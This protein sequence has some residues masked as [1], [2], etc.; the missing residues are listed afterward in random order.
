[1]TRL[2]PF[3]PI[4]KR[5]MKHDTITEPI[6]I[7]NPWGKMIITCRQL[8]IY[9]ET[10]LLSLLVLLNEQDSNTFQ[11]TPYELCKLMGVKPARDTY[12]AIMK[13][14]DRMSE[15]HITMKIKKSNHTHGDMDGHII[16]SITKNKESRKMTLE[17]NKYFLSSF[18]D[19]FI[20]RID[21]Q[22]RSE[23]RGDISKALYRFY[24]GQRPECY[25]IS[26]LKLSKAINVSCDGKMFSLRQKIRK[27]MRELEPGG[28]LRRFMLPYGGKVVAVF[29]S[30]Y[31]SY[32]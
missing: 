30:K 20:T 29:K 24:E 28:Y 21:I 18:R 17:L 26:I 6:I 8:S 14:L 25:T 2:S 19:G 16:N 3:F 11:T 22:M 10:V 23:L 9:D 1:M 31:R 27:S 7:E 15:A 32:N 13:S 5:Q 12:N 4:S